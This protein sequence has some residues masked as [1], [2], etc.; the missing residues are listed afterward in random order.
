MEIMVN[1]LHI[2]APPIFY[3]ATPY[4]LT[5]ANM[6]R[7]KWQHLLIF[8]SLHTIP[9][10]KNGIFLFPTFKG[11]TDCGQWHLTIIKKLGNVQHG[12]I[13]DSLGICNE[14]IQ[15]TKKYIQ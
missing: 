14:R 1:N 9:E 8:C 5:Y 6:S 4:A 3:I 11:N 2:I 13:I 7:I 15:F 12:Y 10:D